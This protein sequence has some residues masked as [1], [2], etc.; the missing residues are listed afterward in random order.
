MNRMDNV[1]DRHVFYI[2]DGTAIT[3]EVLGHAV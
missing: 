3:A 2:S 1:V